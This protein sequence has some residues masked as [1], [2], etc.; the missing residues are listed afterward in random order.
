MNGYNQIKFCIKNPQCE[1]FYL[2]VLPHQGSQ[3]DV[4]K[5]LPCQ[6]PGHAQLS[7]TEAIEMSAEN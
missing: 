5:A 6:G 1:R 4:C 3:I 2:I 7:R